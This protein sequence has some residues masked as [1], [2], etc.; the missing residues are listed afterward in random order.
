MKS[1]FQNLV[2]FSGE[3]C[4]SQ[5]APWKTFCETNDCY[6]LYIT[7]TLLIDS[8]GDW[9][10]QQTVP[11]SCI[12]S[13]QKKAKFLHDMF[14]DY[15]Q[16]MMYQEFFGIWLYLSFLDHD[17]NVLK[18]V[19]QVLFLRH[20]D[21]TPTLQEGTEQC[22]DDFVWCSFSALHGFLERFLFYRFHPTWKGTTQDIF[23]MKVT[24]TFSQFGKPG[25]TQYITKDFHSTYQ[26]ESH[27]TIR[28]LVRE[29]NHVIKLGTGTFLLEHKSLNYLSINSQ[30][31]RFMGDLTVFL[32][33][34]KEL[35]PNTEIILHTVDLHRM[36]WEIFFYYVSLLKIRFIFF[37]YY[38]WFVRNIIN[39]F[40]KKLCK[41]KETFSMQSF[42]L[43]E[44]VRPIFYPRYLWKTRGILEN[45]CKLKNI[46]PHEIFHTE[47]KYDILFYGC[48]TPMI[49]PDAFTEQVLKKESY[50]NFKLY[51]EFRKRLYTL[52]K[53]QKE[54]RPFRIHIIEWTSKHDPKGTYDVDLFEMISQS[55]FT[56]C[57]NANVQYLVRKYYEIPMAG[58][59]LMGNFPD[60]APTILKENIVP[61]TMSMSDK[62]L[63]DT[64]VGC[65]E[66]YQ[67]IHVKKHRLGKVYQEVST[68][69]HTD[70]EFMEDM[71]LYETSKVESPR[72]KSFMEKMGYPNLSALP[73]TYQHDY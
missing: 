55:K 20:L 69:Y 27:D 37:M 2:I 59:V 25:P 9:L 66:E 36:N 32:L 45:L 15:P 31:F 72:L 38:P 58:S 28:Q 39:T 65:I 35:N 23:D 53:T 33:E 57:T 40:Q 67:E 60:Y 61:L 56:I 18:N 49:S 43:K 47:K 8:M 52:L 26:S 34:L 3:S 29:S 50:V 11:K 30:K 64:M 51:Y 70:T 16:E 48:I 1:P 22:T 14:P 12:D 17:K 54:F 71:I 13:F 5:L 46:Q 21:C 10:K 63:V 7:P 41:E 6:F 68:I 73:V 19:A 42:Y 44:T 62:E 4:A 24:S